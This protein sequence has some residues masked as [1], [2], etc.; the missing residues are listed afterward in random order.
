MV[1]IALKQW[2]KVKEPFTQNPD[3]KLIVEGYPLFD[4]RIGKTGAM[5]IY[6]Q[7]V[8]TTHMQRAQREMQ[9]A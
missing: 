4:K 5:T 8:T 6:A 1:Y 7:S 3:D 9:K 2:Q